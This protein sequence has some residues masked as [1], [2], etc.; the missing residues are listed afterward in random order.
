ML[1]SLM[2]G[3]IGRGSVGPEAPAPIGSY[4]EGGYYTGMIQVNDKVYALVL[5]PKA[6]GQSATMLY[7]KSTTTDTPGTSSLNDGWSNTQA[8]IAAD[9]QTHQ[10]ASYCRS[11]VIDGH[12]D[13]YIPSLDE[14]EMCYR[15]FKPNT[16]NNYVL[17]GDGGPTGINGVNSSS[18]PP[19]A[20]Y[21]ITDPGQTSIAYFQLNS[22]E[23]FVSTGY[24]H[25]STQMSYEYNWVQ[26]FS[27]GAQFK[28]GK[29][30]LRRVRAVRRVLLD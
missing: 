24:Y 27:N 5:A 7:I 20:A 4:W 13:W 17:I 8:M 22:Y 18:V 9:A 30:A 16:T 28:G 10:A 25:S 12:S 23:A 15:A 21:T 1:E 3:K 2:M 19:G 26:S 14:L 29:S 11:L 6:Q